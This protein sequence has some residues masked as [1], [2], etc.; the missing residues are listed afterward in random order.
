RNADP[1]FAAAHAERMRKRHADPEFAAAN[2]ERMRKRHAD[3]EYNPLAMLSAQERAD[4]DALK[5]NG[6]SRDDAFRAIGR[7]DLIRPEAAE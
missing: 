3:P 7:A 2:A 4:Y 6:Y 5:R 1:E